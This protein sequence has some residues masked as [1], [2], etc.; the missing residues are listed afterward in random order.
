MMV[1]MFPTTTWL[2]LYAACSPI[3]PQNA[4]IN[5][6]LPFRFFL[7]ILRMGQLSHGLIRR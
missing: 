3:G 7:L 5:L 4:V 2:L 6:S 1:K